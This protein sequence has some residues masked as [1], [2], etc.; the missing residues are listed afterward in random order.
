MW[1]DVIDLRNFYA[2]RL[3]RIAR[4]MVSQRIRK[5]WPTIKGKNVLAL[6]Y[7]TPY[8]K[9]YRKESER[10]VALMPAEQGALAWSKKDPNI[11]V[12]AEET[13]LPLAD[14]SF[15]LALVIHGLEFTSYPREMI[16]ELWRVLKDG[17][18]L[19]LVVPNRVGLWSRRDK[20]PLG[21]GHT[22]SLSQLIFF[23]KENNFT[24]LHAEHALY[25][26]PL[27]S[28][29]F[30]STAPAWENMG[31]RWFPNFSGVLLLEV[32]KQIYAAE[33]LETPCWKSKLQFVKKFAIS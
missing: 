12:L 23:M 10:L 8:V 19:L 13:L 22:Y 28:N 15:D 5:F 27:A 9:F 30:L 25:V 3:G 7:S 11:A 2:S 32:S 18:R 33:P 16:R 21:Q 26:P 24:P 17:G 29:L 6:G 14:Q 20:T 4:R 1:P 31:R